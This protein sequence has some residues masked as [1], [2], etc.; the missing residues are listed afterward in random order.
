MAAKEVQLGFAE[1]IGN[2]AVHRL[3]MTS[4]FF[5]SKI[6]G[7]PAWLNLQDLPDSSRLLCKICQKP[8][9]FLLQV[10]APLSDDRSFHR[11]IFVFCCKDGKCHSQNRSDCFLVLRNQLKRDNKFYSYHPPPELDEINELSLESVALEFKPKAWTSLCDVCGSKGD[12]KCSKC[13]IAQYCC[14]EHQTMDWKSGH[15]NVCT[16]LCAEGA[17]NQLIEGDCKCYDS[18]LTLHNSLF[19]W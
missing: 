15:K 5:P 4:A 8:M 12:K 7:I 10:Y 2:E 16:K 19:S 14:R 3:Q 18:I 13:H 17:Q 11:T 6:G 9:I 1:E